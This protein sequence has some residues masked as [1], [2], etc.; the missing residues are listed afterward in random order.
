MK[1]ILTKATGGRERIDHSLRLSW[2][3]SCGG[4]LRQLL[5]LHLHL[6]SR[7]WCSTRF[8]IFI[9]SGASA[10]GVV[11]PTL[12]V[13][14]LCSV[15]TFIAAPS[16]GVSMVILNLKLTMKISHCRYQL[17]C[18]CSVQESGKV[19]GCLFYYLYTYTANVTPKLTTASPLSWGSCGSQMLQTET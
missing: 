19:E 2:Q 14:L 8:L 11:P 9:Q 1:N 5:I 4:S 15:Q 16:Q 17:S 12:R 7:E 18:L 6:R 10:H 3:G 13:G